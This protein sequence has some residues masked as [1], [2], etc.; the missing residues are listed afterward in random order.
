MLAALSP[1]V[2][3]SITD[4]RFHKTR[5]KL[6]NSDFACAF[7]YGIRLLAELP[8]ASLLLR[9]SSLLPDVCCRDK[10]CKKT[11]K[12]NNDRRIGEYP[13][14]S[15]ERDDKVLYAVSANVVDN[16]IVL[17][18]SRTLPPARLLRLSD[19]CTPTLTTPSSPARIPPP[20]AIRTA[21]SVEDPYS[22]VTLCLSGASS[23]AI[24]NTLN[25]VY[26][27]FLKNLPTSTPPSTLAY[28]VTAAIPTNKTERSA[29]LARRSN[30][31]EI[32]IVSSTKSH[33]LPSF[34]QA[35][36][37]IAREHSHV[38]SPKN[39]RTR[40]RRQAR[41]TLSR[42]RMLLRRVARLTSHQS[43]LRNL[44]L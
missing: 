12:R 27:P 19:S 10:I 9:L 31:V 41:R 22:N 20:A 14:S 36:R 34:F 2:L 33:L 24:L 29:E 4:V 8:I 40:V 23:P 3:R 5:R 38:I 26:S 30:E 21:I 6:A 43:A 42:T 37:H 11:Q 32:T 35:K 1:E 25:H 39:S 15:S 28:N 13:R 7:E 44:L 17:R 18:R 16:Q